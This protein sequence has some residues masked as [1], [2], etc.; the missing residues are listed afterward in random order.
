MYLLSLSLSVRN[1]CP[2]F[3]TPFNFVNVIHF[4]G[5]Y[6]LWSSFLCDFLQ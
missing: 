1:I 4:R 5:R 2:H 6:K 3:D